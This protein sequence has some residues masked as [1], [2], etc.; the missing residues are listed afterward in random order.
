MDF[1]RSDPDGATS[2]HALS[3]QFTSSGF[4]SFTYRQVLILLVTSTSVLNQC[5]KSPSTSQRLID[6]FL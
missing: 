2:S 6:G 4:I 1:C 5:S 3:P